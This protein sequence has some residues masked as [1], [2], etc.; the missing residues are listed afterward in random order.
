MVKTVT[1]AKII[2]VVLIAFFMLYNSSNILKFAAYA[3]D[4]TEYEAELAVK[5][6]KS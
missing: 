2:I 1:I 6:K 3:I 4:T 5:N